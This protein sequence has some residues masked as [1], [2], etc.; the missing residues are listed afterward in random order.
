MFP[1]PVF[2]SLGVCVCVCVWGEG[3]GAGMGTRRR[4]TRYWACPEYDSLELSGND[5]F[6][7]EIHVSFLA[8]F[9]LV[10]DGTSKPAS[11]KSYS[12]RQV[13]ILHGKNSN[14]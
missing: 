13:S 8:N 9:T 14:F 11:N 6:P 12:P 5:G 7:W 3:G 1:I 4:N 10:S 2:F